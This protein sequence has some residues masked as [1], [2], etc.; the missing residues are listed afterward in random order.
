[1]DGSPT[2]QDMQLVDI[3]VMTHSTGELTKQ[4]LDKTAARIGVPIQIVSDHGSDIKKGVELFKITHPDTVY[5]YD[6]SHYMA[7]QLKNNLK[8]DDC[9]QSLLSQSSRCRAQV[10]QTELAFLAPPK[11]RTKARYMHTETHLAWANKMLTYYQQGDFSEIN[12]DYSI[13][14]SVHHL[15]EQQLGQLLAKQVSPLHGKLF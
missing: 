13:N 12:P 4:I 7:I 9:W 5:T 11:Q 10:Q 1:M 3:Q 14:C 15:I 6:V 2:H 8:N